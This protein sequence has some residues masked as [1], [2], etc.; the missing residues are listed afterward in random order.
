MKSN[1]WMAELIVITP[2]AMLVIVS[3]TLTILRLVA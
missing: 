3:F 2:M 1:I